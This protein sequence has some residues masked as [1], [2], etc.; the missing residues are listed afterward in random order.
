V[1][2]PRRTSGCLLLLTLLAL[3]APASGQTTKTAAGP[4][5]LARYLPSQD[6]IFLLEFDGLDA[7]EAAWRKSAAYK[8]LNQTKLGPLLEDLAIQVLDRIKAAAPADAGWPESRQVMALVKAIAEDGIAIGIVK[9]SRS[10]GNTEIIFR[11]GKKSGALALI[12]Q[13]S[14]ASGGK[15]KTSKLGTRTI[16]VEDE[17]PNANAWWAEGDDLLFVPAPIQGI[18]ELVE[19]IDGRAPNASA[20][21]I[22]AELTRPEPGFEPALR[23]FVDLTKVPLPPDVAHSLEGITRVDYRWGFQDDALYSVLRVIAPAPRAGLFTWLDAKVLP[24]FDK[25]SLPPIPSGLTSW[26]VISFNP[27]ALWQKASDYVKE[28]SKKRGMEPNQVGMFVFEEGFTRNLGL[29]LREDILA[30][31][32]PKW[33][34]YADVDLAQPAAGKPRAGLTVEVKDARTFAR[35]LDRLAAF[36]SQIL[37]AQA[38]QNPKAPKFEIKKVDGTSPGYHVVFPPGTIPPAYAQLVSPTILLGKS[39]MIIGLNDT[40]ARAGLAAEARTTARWTPPADAKA[41]LAKV[42]NDL[43]SLSMS[44][45]RTTLP[46]MITSLPSTLAMVNAAIAAQANGAPAFAIKVDPAKMPT[47]EEIRTRLSSGFTAVSIDREGLKVV[48]R[49]AFPSVT[50]QATSG[51]AVALLLPAVQAAREA[52]RLAQCTNN[53]KEI[54]LALAY[55]EQAKG[56]YPAAAI[57]GKD[58]KP[59]L[60]WRVAILPYFG[61]AELFNEF[62][63]DEPWDSPHNRALM[64]RMPKAYLCPSRSTIEPGTTT[65]LS[66]VGKGTTFGQGK[67]VQLREFTDGTSNTIMMV[68]STKATP[69]TKPEDLPFDPAALNQLQ[70]VGSNHPGGFN[71]SLVDCS[72]RFFKSTIDPKLF[73]ALITPNGGEPVTPP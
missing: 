44:D 48:T 29:R 35:T 9:P 24:T 1:I 41:A 15:L 50:N 43:V 8:L 47:A 32:G 61:Q 71:A 49:E 38:A 30:P 31:L 68:E 36:G 57:V 67:P 39:Q 6:L 45:P 7:H 11:N 37:Q 73:R 12:E 20:S 16:T 19:A 42:P 17:G 54:G 28:E 26:T 40:E 21:P 14:K 4:A 70:L 3:A 65:Y 13:I 33:V 25:A 22:R 23:M 56:T 2:A 72:V 63:L 52:A 58:G 66:F 5:P 64:P 69:W 51:V 55:Y 27:L 34:F 62:H 59:L 60:S 10:S 53:L 46:A 18:K